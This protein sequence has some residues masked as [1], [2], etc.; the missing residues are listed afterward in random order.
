MIS[1]VLALMLMAAPSPE[2]VARARNDYNGCLTALMNKSLK[3][4]TTVDAFKASLG[5]ACAAKEQAFRTIVIAVD[6]AAGI[7][8]A[9][10]DENAAF[11]IEDM[12]ANTLETFRGYRAGGIAPAVEQAAA[13]APASPATPPVQPASAETSKPD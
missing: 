9:D 11:E 13:E 4:D 12:V 2:A 3:D 6:T 5:P 10:A 8:R 1:S 7:K